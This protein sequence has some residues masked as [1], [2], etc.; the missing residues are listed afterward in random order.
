MFNES[1]GKFG[2][3]KRCFLGVNTLC[4]SHI[5]VSIRIETL[6]K[7]YAKSLLLKLIPGPLQLKRLNL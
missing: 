3:P 5:L 4:A 6:D 2:K 1:E 7:D